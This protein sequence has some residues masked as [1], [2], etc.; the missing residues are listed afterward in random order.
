MG[1]LRGPRG[2]SASGRCLNLSCTW[3]QSLGNLVFVVGTLC[4]HACT[5]EHFISLV[6]KLNLVWTG[7][8]LLKSNFQHSEVGIGT[9][10][11]NSFIFFTQTELGLYLRVVA[12]F[13]HWNAEACVRE[14]TSCLLG[15]LYEFYLVELHF[16]GEAFERNMNTG[17]LK[18]SC[19]FCDFFFFFSS[20][21][22]L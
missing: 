12:I 2:V 5:C 20:S 22:L 21:C 11:W 3:S 9:E 17:L 18:T 14:V 10:Q 19:N 13:M 8:C 4:V 16:L 1:S 15:S 7:A 6:L